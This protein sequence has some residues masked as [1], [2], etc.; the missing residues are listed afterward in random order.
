MKG[1]RISNARTVPVIAEFCARSTTV[2]PA[3]SNSERAS[4]SNSGID[5]HRQSTNT[6][7]CAIGTGGQF[8]GGGNIG[9]TS[10]LSESVFHA[11]IC[12]SNSNPRSGYSR[13]GSCLAWEL[14]I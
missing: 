7:Q 5:H 9:T 3:A 6:G 14:Q 12:C 13:W 11:I 2:W 1:N 8:G 10:A 4:W